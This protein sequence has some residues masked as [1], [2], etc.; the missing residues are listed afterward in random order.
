VESRDAARKVRGEVRANLNTSKQR[1]APHPAGFACHLPQQSWGRGARSSRHRHSTQFFFVER[2]ARRYAKEWAHFVRVLKSEE[3]ASSAGA[4]GR[5][6]LVLAEAA[7][8][9]LETGMLAFP[10]DFAA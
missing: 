2:Y 5:E 7:Y 3:A 8:R 1:A 9:S 4:E 6:A 10:D